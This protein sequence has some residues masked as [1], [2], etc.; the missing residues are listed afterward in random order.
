MLVFLFKVIRPLFKHFFQLIINITSSKFSSKH[1]KMLILIFNFILHGDQGCKTTT[2]YMHP[3][4]TLEMYSGPCQTSWMSQGSGYASAFKLVQIGDLG[5]IFNDI[6]PFSTTVPLLYPLKISENQR[7][8]NVFRVY[9]STTLVE[10]GLIKFYSI[11]GN[12][13]HLSLA[14][15][16]MLDFREE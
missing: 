6:N 7:F 10:N 3:Q 8:S 2:D 1:E 4:V 16:A 11:S 5:Y 14:K 12:S 9:R 13:K 15:V